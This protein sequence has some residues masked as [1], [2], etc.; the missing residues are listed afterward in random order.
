MKLKVIVI[1][2]RTINVGERRA[3]EIR[4]SRAK[5]PGKSLDEVM[6]RRWLGLTASFDDLRCHTP[7]PANS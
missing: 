1:L 4:V 6:S 7:E 5:W 2:L 3:S